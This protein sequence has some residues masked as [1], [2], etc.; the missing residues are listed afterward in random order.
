M[1]VQD[2][3]D[4]CCGLHAVCEKR[5][6]HE[7][8]TVDLYY[9]DEELDIYRGRDGSKYSEDEIEQFRDVLYTMRL[10]EVPDWLDCLGK[11]GVA[12]PSELESEIKL[13]VSEL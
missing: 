7:T 12:L 11:R 3:N 13:I 9:D 1:S 10:D 2:N 8:A 4:Y 6:W 5:A